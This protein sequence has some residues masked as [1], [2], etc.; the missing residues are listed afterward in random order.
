MKYTDVGPDG[1]LIGIKKGNCEM[2][3]EA[4]PPTGSSYREL[5]G[6]YK[7]SMLE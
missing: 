3:E 6:A 2:A 7:A 1:E 4:E 5:V